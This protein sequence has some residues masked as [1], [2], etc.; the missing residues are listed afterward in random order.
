VAITSNQSSQQ[1]FDRLIS[2]NENEED[3]EQAIKNT[4]TNLEKAAQQLGDSLFLSHV[5]N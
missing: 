5:Q 4:Y 1:Y 3:L 2:I